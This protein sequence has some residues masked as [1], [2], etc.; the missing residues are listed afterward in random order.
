[1]DI[2]QLTAE[3]L[4]ERLEDWYF[5][6]LAP[7]VWRGFHPDGRKTFLKTARTKGKA[8]ERRSALELAQ[9]DVL[10]DRLPCDRWPHCEHDSPERCSAGR[11]KAMRWAGR[12]P[13][14]QQVFSV[15]Q[16]RRR[17]EYEAKF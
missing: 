6:E 11:Y 15:E 2:R 12:Q 17:R 13:A 10:D 5:R 4:D 3:Q 7:G 16:L 8:D 1:M 9:Q 14:Q